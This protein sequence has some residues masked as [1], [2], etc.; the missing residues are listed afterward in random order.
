MNWNIVYKKIIENAKNKKRHKRELT[1]K[2]YVYYERHHILPRCLGGKNTRKNYVL[3]TAREHFFCHKILTKIY[4]SYKLWYALQMMANMKRYNCKKSELKKITE[5]FAYI[6]SKDCAFRRLT[7]EQIAK[8][9]KTL[10][11]LYKDHPEIRQQ[12]VKTNRKTILKKYEKMTLEERQEHCKKIAKGAI[13]SSKQRAYERSLNKIEKPKKE[14]QYKRSEEWRKHQSE[15]HWLKGKHLP[16]EVK[17]KG[18][19]TQSLGKVKCIETG[20]IFMSAREAQNLHSGWS[21]G[22]IL[23]CCR[24]KQ[25]IHNGYH[26]EWADD[27]HK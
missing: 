10:N 14:K 17:I 15:N 21:H 27:N 19:I 20:E 26:F 12:M 22:G 5:D 3:L 16:E 6:K 13:L 9:Q 11:Q 8:R 2:N 18:Q 25:K 24:N 7:K 23:K 1:N 4:S